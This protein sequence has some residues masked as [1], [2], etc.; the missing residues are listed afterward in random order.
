MIWIVLLGLLA[1]ATQ[2]YIILLL[3]ALGHEKE[4]NGWSDEEALKRFIAMPRPANRRAY[5]NETL[6]KAAMAQGRLALWAVARALLLVGGAG[7]LLTVLLIVYRM[8]TA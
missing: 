7:F 5:V 2:G 6:R 8:A 3:I 4:T 1:A